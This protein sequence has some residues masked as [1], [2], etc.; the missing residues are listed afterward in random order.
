MCDLAQRIGIL[1]SLGPDPRAQLAV[2]LCD[3]YRVARRAHVLALA[4]GHGG[5][6]DG[7]EAIASEL[8]ALVA[9]VASLA[10]A[11]IEQPSGPPRTEAVSGGCR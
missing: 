1:Q 9:E 6:A 11:G 7:F 8:R 4:E 3:L 2:R 5:L 10:D